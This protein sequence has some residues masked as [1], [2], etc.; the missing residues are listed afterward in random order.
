MSKGNKHDL[1]VALTVAE[2]IVGSLADVCEDIRIAGSIRREKEKVGDIELV[3]VPKVETQASLVGD[4]EPVANL[5]LDR[6]DELMA[7]KKI[8]P[9][10]FPA[11]GERQRKFMVK[12]R[13]GHE[14]QIDLYMCE[15]D[16]FGAILLI[17]TGSQDFSRWIVTSRVQGKLQIGAMPIG[18]RQSKGRLWKMEGD[19]WKPV[20]TYT[21]EDYFNALEIPWIP[22]EKRHNDEWFAWLAEL[23][24]WLRE[25]E[26]GIAW[27]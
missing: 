2:Q 25:S 18:M 8:A 4:G 9:A 10:P 22:P 5:L 12:T 27:T 7:Q 6:L 13:L 19:D 24:E 1:D 26:G 17:R 16:N 23:D 20:P 3:A 11:W 15:P 21:E 14:Y